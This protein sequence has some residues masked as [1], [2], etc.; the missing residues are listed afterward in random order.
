[1]NKA[2]I[3]GVFTAMMIAVVSFNS[4]D[5]AGDGDDPDTP[6]T[7]SSYPEKAAVKYLWLSNSIEHGETVHYYVTFDNHA[8]RFRYDWYGPVRNYET[9]EYIS[10]Y[11][12]WESEAVNH[13]NKTHWKS[14]YNGACDDQ[15]YNA[16]QKIDQSFSTAQQ[17]LSR[18]YKKQPAQKIYAGKP[19]D[20][21][22]LTG[23]SGTTTCGLWNDINLFVEVDAGISY[24]LWEAL[25]VSLNVPA[26]AFTKT[27]DITWLTM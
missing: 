4:C 12:H 26:V 15:P 6:D 22:I 19:C 8:K 10:L 16:N 2:F 7:S 9:G 23:S 24:T 21:Y 18:G 3:L 14:T 11:D 13:I 20:M 25:E 1:M 27:L 17:L 5:K